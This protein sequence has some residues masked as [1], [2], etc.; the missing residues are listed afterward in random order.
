MKFCFKYHNLFGIIII[1]FLSFPQI[2]KAQSNN[3]IFIMSS[4]GRIENISIKCEVTTK[5]NTLGI[6]LFPNPVIARTNLKIINP[7]PI[8][9]SF[10][11]SIWGVDGFNITNGKATGQDLFQGLPLDL[12]M[13]L[14][15]TYFIQIESGKYIDAIKFS[16]T[17]N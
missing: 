3:D 7:S 17:N 12:S 4:V 15:G 10:K 9:E 1:I 16:K 8:N 13:L 14:D 5:F 2:L 11:I 6:K